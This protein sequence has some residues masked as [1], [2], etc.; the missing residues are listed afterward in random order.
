MPHRVQSCLVVLAKKIL[1]SGRDL[2]MEHASPPVVAQ[3]PLVDRNSQVSVQ[4]KR[5]RLTKHSGAAFP[6]ILVKRESAG[7]I[8]DQAKA[9][10]EIM[11]GVESLFIVHAT[12]T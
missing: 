2:L 4:C 1:V 10:G 7:V 6:C 9:H 3:L 11:R 8:A 5:V 12:G